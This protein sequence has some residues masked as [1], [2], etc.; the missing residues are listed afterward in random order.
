[1]AKNIKQTVLVLFGTRPEAIKLAPV[2]NELRVNNELRVVVG[3]TGQHRE[4]IDQVMADFDISPDFDLDVMKHNQGLEELTVKLIEG[5]H[6]ILNDCKPDMIVVQG[7]TTTA[8]CGALCGAYQRIK[9]A[10]IEAGLRSGN[11]QSPFPE[12]INRILI[13]NMADLHF[14]PTELAKENLIAEGITENVHVVGNTVVDAFMNI[15]DAISKDEK[16]YAD[17]FQFSRKLNKFILVTGHRRESFG[18]GFESICHALKEI[19]QSDDELDIVYPV[20][21]NPNVQEPVNRILGKID[22]IH[23]IKPVSYPNLVWLLKQCYL[24]LTD[25]GGIQEEAP[26]VGKPVL[27]MRDVTERMEGVIAGTSLLVGSNC[28]KI[29]R[30][31]IRLLDD[32]NAYHKMSKQSNP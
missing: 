2:V 10:H 26:S 23:L 7:D 16:K 8:F 17:A 25:S 4:M 6:N 28:Q 5:I 30:E 31:T 29:V 20:H 32:R 22:N 14:S 1:M 3:V 27:V 24:V 18:S 21:L 12:E 13:S 11:K 19:A 9:I 15:S